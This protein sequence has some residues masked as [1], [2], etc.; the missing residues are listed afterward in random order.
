MTP[1]PREGFDP[2]E[3]PRWEEDAF[4]PEAGPLPTIA[5]RSASQVAIRRPE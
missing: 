4:W 5:F 1:L 3:R 2:G